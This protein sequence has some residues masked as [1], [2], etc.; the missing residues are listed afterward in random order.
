[1]RGDVASPS[2][3]I[4]G[5]NA[6]EHAI[7]A[8]LAASA[9]RPR[10]LCF[11]AHRNP[12]ID[13][14]CESYSVGIL[15]E[16]SAV[17]AFA[18]QESANMA[19]VGPE[20]PLAAGVADAL[21]SAGIPVVGP[22][23]SLA[24]LESS[25]GFTRDLLQKYGVPG[26]PFFRRFDSLDGLDALFEQFPATYVLKADGLAGGKG[27]RV[28]GEH[29][30][31]DDEA[32]EYAAH[33]LEDGGS[34]VFEEKIDGVEFSL[35]SFCDGKTLRHMP[36]VQD[37]KRAFAGD[38]GPNTGGMGTYTGPDG[39]LPFLTRADVVAAERANEQVAAALAKECGAPYQ[40]ILY[41]GFMAVADGIRIIEY[42]A[43]FGDP[44]ALNLLALLETDFVEICRAIV[45]ETLHQVP[46]TFSGDATVCKYIVPNAYPDA[47]EQ[48]TRVDLPTRLPPGVVMYLGAVAADGEGMV[49]AGTRTAGIVARADTIAAAEAACE[50]VAQQMKGP[51][52]HR[53]DIGTEALLRTRVSKMAELRSHVR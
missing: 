51:F 26:N 39:G 1:M 49:V 37:H 16:A 46:V 28:F 18:L 30:H 44:E 40:G 32:R 52:R 31:S 27:V 3:L 9:C 14:L 8:A 53:E 13:A 20:V 38:T 24:R 48:G 47:V 11:G 45:D 42:N 6:R 15:A 25:K 41:G 17:V 10:L 19:V 5:S 21:W 50:S 29:M 33:L 34:F 7:A 4:V 2:I 36:P 12:A 23:Q 43:R 22:R 35:L